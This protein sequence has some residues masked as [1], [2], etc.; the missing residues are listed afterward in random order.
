MTFP[1]LS[2]FAP[3]RGQDT[4]EAARAYLKVQADHLELSGATARPDPACPF[5]WEVKLPN[6]RRF[7]DNCRAVVYLPGSLAGGE[8][9]DFEVCWD[10]PESKVA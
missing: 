9:G 1:H 10:E 2:I 5:V 6:E 4:A 8:F 7:G 3:H